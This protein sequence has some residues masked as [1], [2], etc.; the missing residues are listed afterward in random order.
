M[1][2]V[3]ANPLV[4]VA[5]LKIQTGEL[6]SGTPVIRQKSLNN[7]KADAAEQD[8]HDVAR[9]LFGLGENEV[10]G[11]VLRKQYDLVDEG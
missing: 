7:V 9:A 6:P 3:V 8:I 10:L 2:A 11:V 5:V 4:S 1:M